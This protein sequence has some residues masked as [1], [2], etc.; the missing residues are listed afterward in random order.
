MEAKPIPIRWNRALS[1]Y[2]S[3]PFLRYAGDQYGWLGGFAQGVE[4]R[5]ILPYTIVEKAFIRMVRFRVETIATQ[6][7]LSL[8]EERMFLNAAMG[9]FRSIGADLVIP[10]STNTIFR[11]VPEGAI[12]APYGS[13]IVDLTEAE[14]T[15][16]NRLHSKHRNAVRNARKNGVQIKSGNEYIDTAYEMARSTLRRSQMPF[17]SADSFK[18]LFDALSENIG[19]FI[20][21]HRGVLQGCAVIPYSDD[22]AYYL[23][24]GSA[25][26]PVPGAMNL[27]HW[28]AMRHFSEVGT[29][30]YDFVGTRIAPEKGSKQE[31]LK[32]FK[33]RFGGALFRGYMWKYPIRKWKYELYQLGVLRLRGGD[34]VDLERHKMKDYKGPEESLVEACQGA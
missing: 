18:R 24:G 28:E 12:A 33:E 1:I 14:E 15:R 7:E 21:E 2:A 22:S 10:A 9:Y 13:Y 29:K 8:C 5:C 27:L 31:G 16:W 25:A 4:L 6:G 11:T 20:A 3:E 30:R 32:M 34:I 26:K 23:Y 19:V 17:L